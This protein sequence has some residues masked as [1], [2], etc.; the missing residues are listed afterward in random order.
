MTK[1]A[2]NDKNSKI[3]RKYTKIIRKMVKMP[4][5]KH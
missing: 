1:N 2:E 3:N 5:K 4:K